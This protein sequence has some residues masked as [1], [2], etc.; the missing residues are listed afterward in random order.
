MVVRVK[1]VPDSL[2]QQD[3]ISSPLPGQFKLSSNL[4]QSL[5]SKLQTFEVTKPIESWIVVGVYKN[6]EYP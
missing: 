6:L 3:F 4:I 5:D 1:I 2:L